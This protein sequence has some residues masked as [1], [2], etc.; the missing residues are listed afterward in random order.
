MTREKILEWAKSIHQNP[1]EYYA[2]GF[3]AEIK[4]MIN[5]YIGKNNA[6]YSTLAEITSDWQAD[7]A[8]AA[9][10]LTLKRFI[11]VVERDLISGISLNR[12]IQTDV[13]S[14]ILEQAQEI[15]ND[16]KY[17]PAAAAILIGATLEEFLRNWVEDEK[18]D[19]SG[20]KQSIDC[21][22]KV[23]KEKELIDKQDLKDIISWAGIRNDAAHGHWENLNDRKRII[24]MIEGVNYFM[25]RKIKE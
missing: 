15:L 4:E 17:H 2:S 25:R 20:K 10:D 14:D 21:Y 9:A 22:S 7:D 16:E 1:N 13:V 12:K 8:I 6:F 24:L 5:S 18:L 3:V 23:L 11:S 19:I